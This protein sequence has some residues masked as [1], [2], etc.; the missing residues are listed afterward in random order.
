[1][2]FDEF[3]LSVLASLL[4]NKLGIFSKLKPNL[5]LQHATETLDTTSPGDV[6]EH[7]VRRFKA[8]DAWTH[9]PNFLKTVR[10]PLI[11]ILIE[12]QPSSHYRLPSMVLESKATGEWYVFSRGRMS[13]EGSGGGIRNSRNILELVKSA[14]APVGVWVIPQNLLNDLDNGYALW[15]EVRSSA[16]PL[17]AVV[18]G[19]HSWFEIESNV[20]ELLA[21]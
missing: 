21:P 8:F 4:A 15:P 1:M 20:A 13:F 18:A 14:G 17:L 16:V 9:F 3:G 10:E 2:G 7:R 12:D 11:S 5:P 6:Q 19:E